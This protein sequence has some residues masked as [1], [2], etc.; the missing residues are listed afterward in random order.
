[1]LQDQS[2]QEVKSALNSLC[3]VVKKSGRR[4]DS[5]NGKPDEAISGKISSLY[6][7]GCYDSLDLFDSILGIV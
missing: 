3:Y 1:M 7:P 5:S 6:V 4:F 2:T